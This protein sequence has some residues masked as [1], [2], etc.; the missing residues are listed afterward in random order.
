MATCPDVRSFLTWKNAHCPET[1]TRGNKARSVEIT[2]W[3]D[4]GNVALAIALTGGSL[5]CAAIL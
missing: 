4:P 5:F 2:A 3:P 1:Q